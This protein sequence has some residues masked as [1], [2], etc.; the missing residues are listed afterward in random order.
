[1]LKLSIYKKS[2]ELKQI[3]KNCYRG[4]LIT[5]VE[6]LYKLANENKSVYIEYSCH[7]RKPAKVVIMMQCL[8][9]LKI[10]EEGKIYTVINT[11]IKKP[12]KGKENEDRRSKKPGNT[13]NW[14]R[15][16]NTSFNLVGV[17]TIPIPNDVEIL[18]F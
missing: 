18:V 11:K 3:S 5:T 9:V 7:G 17:N 8:W 12:I 16:N 14:G 15:R 2:F 13:N 10:I 1:M 6:E 4:T